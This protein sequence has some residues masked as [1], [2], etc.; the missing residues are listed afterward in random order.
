[1]LPINIVQLRDEFE[2]NLCFLIFPQQL[3]HS[4]ELCCYSTNIFVKSDLKRNRAVS[5]LLIQWETF[6][7]L[8]YYNV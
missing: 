2:L 5:L 1:M 7:N 4:P 8:L 6:L 3:N